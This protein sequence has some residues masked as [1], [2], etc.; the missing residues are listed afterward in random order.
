MNLV[1]WPLMGGPVN[2]V[3]QAE[4]WA[5]PQSAQAPPRPLLAVPIV[6]D[7]PTTAS[8]PIVL[9]YDNDLLLC[10]FNVPIKRLN[11]VQRQN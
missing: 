6:A 9:L 4:D 3:H 7:H 10:S 8:V 5:G 11:N 2:L 1:Q